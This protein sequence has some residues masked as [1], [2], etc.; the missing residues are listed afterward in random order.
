[1]HS[2]IKSTRTLGAPLHKPQF[3]MIVGTRI[4]DDLEHTSSVAVL[5]HSGLLDRA[6]RTIGWDEKAK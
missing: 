1:M 2:A 4:A 6:I 5:L 3:N